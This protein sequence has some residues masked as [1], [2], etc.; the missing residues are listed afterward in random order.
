MDHK[1]EFPLGASVSWGWQTLWASFGFF[2]GFI[3]IIFGIQGIINFVPE[4][5]FGDNV[6]AQFLVAL[7]GWLV[8]AVLEMGVIVVTLK[9]YDGM[10]AELGD[11]F[12]QIERILI[13]L[14]SSFIYAMMVLIGLVFLIVP[15]IYIALRFHFFGFF[16]VEEGCGPIEA[17]SR[18]AEITKDN[19]GNL[20]LFWLIIFGINIV[21]LL[22]LGIGILIT[23]VITMLA[24]AY[25]YRHL[26]PAAGAAMPADEPPPAPVEA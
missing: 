26:K 8:G 9:F 11:L 6:M 14:V 16:I 3:L 17:L 4:L 21:G 23:S 25:V 18:S 10:R 5:V 24:T 15:G 12:S 2:V 20:F 7:V 1:E 22:A 19:V 13:Y